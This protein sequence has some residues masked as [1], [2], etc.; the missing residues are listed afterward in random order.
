MTL[1]RPWTHGSSLATGVDRGVVA[2]W[3]K[4]AKLS[5]RAARR[6]LRAELETRRA[7]SLP[8]GVSV[9]VLSHRE[10]VNLD[11]C[12]SSL[13]RQTLGRELFEVIVI[14]VRGMD[15]EIDIIDRLRRAHPDLE[16][17]VVRMGVADRSQV[18]DAGI[19]A[20]RRLHTTLI[21]ATDHVSPAF[22]EVLLAAVRPGLIPVAAVVDVAPDG[23]AAPVAGN[24][25]VALTGAKLAPTDLVRDFG[26]GARSAGDDDS[27]FWLAVA[28]MGRLEFAQ[29]AA[30][31]GAVYHRVGAGSV[32]QPTLDERVELISQLDGLTEYADA[33]GL[34]R[35]RAGIGTQAAAINR[36]L[37]E[38]PAEHSRTVRL[39]DHHRVSQTAYDRMNDGLGRGLAVAYEFPP[40]AGSSAVV[41]AKRIRARGEVADVVYNAMDRIRETDESIRRISGPFIDRE[42]AVRTPSYFSNWRSMEQF[43]VEG[44]DVVRRWEA[45]KGPYRWVYSRAHFA[46]SHFLAAA[47]K[48]ANPAVTWTAEFSDPLSRDIMDSERGSDVT[49]GRL[50][51]ELRRGMSALEL[52]LPESRNCFVWCEELSYA[53]ADELIF[54]NENQLEHMLGY[55]SNPDVAEM[56]RKKAVIAPHPTL[57]RE[58][59]SMVDVDYSVDADAVN[60]AY[61]G[62]FYTTRGLDDVL[63][64]VAGL[65]GGTRALVRIH[66]FTAK[67]AELRRRAAELGIADL[68]QVGPYV[69]YLEF[70]SLTTRFDCLIVNDATTGASH[71]MNP[72]LPSKWSDYRGSGTPVWG[73]VEPG[74]PLSGQPIQFRSPIGAIDAAQEVLARLVRGKAVTAS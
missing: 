20:A 43:A 1:G 40:Y 58:F 69:R 2:E 67:P 14:L 51:D 57:P 11:R 21:D 6:D 38:H 26:Y 4:A 28:L 34:S 37:R 62:N 49:E 44:M 42:A 7:R 39:L 8:R 5:H 31:Q 64:A 68:V 66:V 18:R 47:F 55:C 63:G 73:L 53:L 36:Y 12:L 70:L 17:R 29:C 48:L 15:R 30:A 16:L 71:A 56:A 32:E 3:Q 35:I 27:A 74:S 46:A 22:L 45:S 50:L 59:Y 25:A 72:Y 24:R 60:L 19:A 54:T 13:A 23:G 10:A 41:A 65:D 61:F 52:P 33:T 9:V